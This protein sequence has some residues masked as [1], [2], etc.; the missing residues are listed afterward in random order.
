MIKYLLK[1]EFKQ[2]I[3]NPFLPRMILVFPF[4]V[5]L[6]FPWAANYE[7]RNMNASIVDNDHSSYSRRLTQTIVSS[8]Y[9]KLAD[10]SSTYNEA[11]KSIEQNK[12]DV[13]IQIPANFEKDIINRNGTKIMIS[14]NAVNGMKGGIA[15][16]YLSQIVSKFNSTILVERFPQSAVMSNSFIQTDSLFQF[17]K[18]LNYQV[19][20]VPALKIG[21]AHV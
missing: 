10:F 15:V 14:P 8:E 3:R 6:V 17:N 5:L 11:L 16:A 7:I 13:I 18:E 1:K 2:I 9:F 4:V 12:A 20:M 21:R 19:F